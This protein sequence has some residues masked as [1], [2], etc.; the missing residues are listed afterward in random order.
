MIKKNVLFPGHKSVES[1]L[2]YKPK[3]TVVE[4]EQISVA[5]QTGVRV[6]RVDPP[7]FAAA[8]STTT[9]SALDVN[10]YDCPFECFEQYDTKLEL[11]AHID[12]DHREEKNGNA[13]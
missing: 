12:S 3:S 13:L 1:L 4:R 11:L 2:N 10:V 6:V 8:S 7:E 9:S 5:L